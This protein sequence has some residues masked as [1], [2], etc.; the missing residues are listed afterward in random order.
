MATCGNRAS[1]IESTGIDTVLAGVLT[2]ARIAAT[3]VLA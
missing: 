1:G 2:A 3:P